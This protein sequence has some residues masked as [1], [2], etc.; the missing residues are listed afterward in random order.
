MTQVAL[1]SFGVLRHCPANEL[2]TASLLEVICAGGVQ[3]TIRKTP[4]RDTMISRRLRINRRSHRIADSRYSVPWLGL[5]CSF[6]ALEFRGAA[7]CFAKAAPLDF[8]G[9][10]SADGVG[11]TVT[12]TTP[13][14]MA[15]G[16]QRPA[17]CCKK[18][19]KVIRGELSNSPFTRR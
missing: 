11:L 4:G 14:P 19:S 9:D 13:T 7:G 12:G 16:R 6:D 10:P 1:E 18:I 2:L 15:Y 5:R 3:L 17:T 8:R